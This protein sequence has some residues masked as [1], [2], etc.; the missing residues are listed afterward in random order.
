[1]LFLDV[2]KLTTRKVIAGRD[3]SAWVIT[4]IHTN[5]CIGTL[6]R[7]ADARPEIMDLCQKLLDFQICGEF[8]LTEIGHGLDAR[9]LETT[10]TAQPDGSF[11]L[12]SPNEASAKAMPPTTPRCGMPRVAVVFAR[13]VVEQEDRGVKPFAV[14][15]C[16][17]DQMCPG[18]TSK[19]LPTRPGTRAIDHSITS[20]DNVFLPPH[21]LLG[22]I[23]KAKNERLDFLQQI[24]RVSVGTLSLSIMAVA[25]LKV[26]SCIAATYSKRRF[27]GD[28]GQRRSILTFSTQYR[29]IMQT[30]IMGVI[31]D[32]HGRWTVD[33]F[34]SESNQLLKHALVTIFKV[35]AMKA[36]RILSELC[37]RL[38]WQGLYAHNQINEL[39][40]TLQGNTIAEGDT[41]VLTIRKKHVL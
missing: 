9:N 27:I 12:H 15:L 14:R 40:L 23:Q 18:I 10:A 6:S 11:R 39:A 5:L 13:L 26:S 25:A 32:L 16:D 34:M 28:A 17:S 35:G 20:F 19:P 3:M 7:F 21:S 2:K 31:L 24:E 29:P 4:S 38:G 36:P 22:P 41:L 33:K 37:E 8:M 1:M 30:W